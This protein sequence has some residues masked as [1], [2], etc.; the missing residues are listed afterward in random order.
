M[1]RVLN[2]ANALARGVKV[3]KTKEAQS[4]G[5]IPFSLSMS[6]SINLEIQRRLGVINDGL[7]IDAKQL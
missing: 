2:R 7:P 1:F 4:I 5:L 6:Y 3:G